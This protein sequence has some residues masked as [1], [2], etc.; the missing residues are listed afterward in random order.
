V[1]GGDVAARREAV[2]VVEPG[3]AVAGS[4]ARV[5]GPPAAPLPLRLLQRPG[6]LPGAGERERPVVVVPC[7]GVDGGG[8]HTKH[9]AL[10]FVLP[11]FFREQETATTVSKKDRARP[12]PERRT[13][14]WMMIG[15]NRLRARCGNA[16]AKAKVAR[17]RSVNRL[18]IAHARVHEKGKKTYLVVQ[19]QPGAL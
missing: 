3:T 7:C 12:R 11:F 14:G 2:V 5:H 16:V 4:G 6:Q 17:G 10:A 9:P 18:Y 8:K 19:L 1:R 15:L 13:A